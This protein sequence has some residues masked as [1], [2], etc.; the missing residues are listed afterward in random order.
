VSLPGAGREDH[1]APLLGW[2]TRANITMGALALGAVLTWHLAVVLTADG[3]GLGDLGVTLRA[4]VHGH[5]L[6]GLAGSGLPHADPAS[7]IVTAIVWVILL[8]TLFG[9]FVAWAFT[10]AGFRARRRGGRGFAD[11]GQ[12]REGLGL[13]RARDSARQTRPSL[14]DSERQHAEIEQIGLSLG[15]SASGHEPVVLPLEDHVVIVAA[16]GAGKSRDLM[17]P[18]AL[19][20]PGALVVT[21]T[22]ADIIDVIATTRAKHGQIW[23]FDPLDRIGWPDP[24][25]WDPVAGCK[26]GETAI[27]R[28]LAFAAGLGADDTSSTNTGFFRANASSAL[29]RLLHAAD[30]DGRP[31]SDVID[32][33]VHLDDGAELAQQIIRSSKL[34]QAE[35]MWAGMLRSVATG[36]DETVASSRQTLQ[37]A[38]E[39]MA[40]R[41]VLRWVTPRDGVPSFDPAAFVASRDT[42][43]LVADANS[44][45][46]VAPLCSMLLQEVVDTAKVA[47]ARRPGGRLDPPLR[48]VGDEIANVA[49]LPKLPDLGTDA[50]GFGMQLILALQSIAQARRRW[51]ADGANTLLDNMPAEIL[52]GGLTDTEALNRYAVLVGEVELTRATTSYDPMT[53]QATN[54]SEQLTDRKALRAD[55]AR[56]IPD[57]HGLLIYRNR[58]AVLLQMTPW[59]EQDGGKNLE[60]D[61]RET[62]RLRIAAATSGPA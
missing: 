11:A 12:V 26:H 25:V 43:V 39:P 36:A 3:V 15:V 23:V 4:L 38:I 22:R 35:P 21:C 40:L 51:G 30:L 10:W 9:L 41:K 44:S 34:P 28:G 62:E 16:T 17:I 8:L 20:A 32:W 6:S 37:Q 49:P 56:Q 50:R 13:Q 1:A 46:N 54:S 61:R 47:A 42:L 45:T 52:L 14:T 5:P 57:R 55:E 24:M 48:L 33:A 27:S 19:S 53:G 58:A 29:T 60:S 18:A 2:R 7:P 59:Y 31:V